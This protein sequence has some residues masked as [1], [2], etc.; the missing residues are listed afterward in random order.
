M[1]FTDKAALWLEMVT[2]FLSTGTG[3]NTTLSCV[4]ALKQTGSVAENLLRK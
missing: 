1:N 2:W 4:K 3:I